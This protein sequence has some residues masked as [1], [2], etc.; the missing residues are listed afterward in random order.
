[1]NSVAALHGQCAHL[2]PLLGSWQG[3]GQG[4]Y[5]T[6]SPFTYTEQVTFAHVGKPFLAY[7]QRTKGADGAPLHAETG[8]WRPVGT[9]KL[10]VLLVHP[11]GIV[12][13][14]EGSVSVAGGGVEIL[15]NAGV[16]AAGVKAGS[17]AEPAGEVLVTPTAKTVLA[18]RRHIRIE[19]DTLEYTFSMAAV[20]QPLQRHL[21]ASL[22]R[23]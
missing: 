21:S 16:G 4:H 19:G 1:M 7:T 14:A 15:L 10:E 18:T 8:Y 11:S 12:E 9:D 13:L 5:P 17:A 23:V 6:I 3:T 22:S 20:G 2:A